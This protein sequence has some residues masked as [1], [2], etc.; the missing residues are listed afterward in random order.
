MGFARPSD[1]HFLDP[2]FNIAAQEAWDEAQVDHTYG[3]LRKAPTPK[4]T[5]TVE[6][7]IISGEPWPMNERDSAELKAIEA[8]LET[9]SQAMTRIPDGLGGYYMH[10]GEMSSAEKPLSV[11]NSDA[12]VFAVGIAREAAAKEEAKP[13]FRLFGTIG[14]FGKKPEGIQ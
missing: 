7:E 12:Q 5:D 8:T 3:E 13:G 4:A 6:G 1:K 14:G 2:S 9:G 11:L 10:D